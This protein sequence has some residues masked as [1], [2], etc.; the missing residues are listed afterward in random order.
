MEKYKIGEVVVFGGRSWRVL[1]VKKEAVLI[2]TEAIISQHEYH[3][4]AEEITWANCALRSYLNDTFY[5]QFTESEKA[6]I[7]PVLNKN[8]DNEWYG[9]TGGEDTLDTIFLLSIEEVACQYFGDSSDLL[10]NPGK[11]QRY[12]LQ[13]KDENNSQREAYLDGY[14]WWWWLRSPGRANRRAVYIHGDGNIGIQ[15]NGTFN[16]NSNTRHRLTNDNRGGV[17]PA[18]WLKMEN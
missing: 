13:R 6:Q 16:Y 2:L 5:N 11:N 1:S 17:R 10:Y 14:R 7:L 9:T 8:L 15:G 12:W 18:L 4:T 3:D